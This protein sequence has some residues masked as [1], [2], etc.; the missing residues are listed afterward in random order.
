M[1]KVAIC[2]AQLGPKKTDKFE[3]CVQHV[4]K[5]HGMTENINRNLEKTLLEE[6]NKNK[7][8]LKEFNEIKQKFNRV[9]DQI[10]ETN[11][12]NA[13]LLYKNQ[14][15]CNTSLNERQKIK[16]VDAISKAIS[17]EEAKNIYE[18]LLTT[19][20]SLNLFEKHNK[21]VFSNNIKNNG[22]N[23]LRE[24]MEIKNTN[25]LFVNRNK[26]ELG[27]SIDPQIDR[28]KALAGIRK[29]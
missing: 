6:Q 7:N 9:V 3:R 26:Q 25:S 5:Q 20:G 29:K 11:I 14:A 13:Q 24:A 15:L 12:L 21:T 27:S 16:F 23:S 22:P 28:L 10:E 1:K 2:H 17:V 18:T 4:K 8:L 19:V